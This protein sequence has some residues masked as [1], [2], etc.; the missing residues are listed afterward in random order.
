METTAR[1]YISY[2]VYSSAS[3]GRSTSGLSRCEDGTRPAVHKHEEGV[4]SLHSSG[5]RA[6]LANTPIDLA[7][8]LA[9]GLLRERG[10]VVARAE[11]VDEDKWRKQ[12][13]SPEDRA[14]EDANEDDQLSICDHTHRLVVVAY[15]R[16]ETYTEQSASKT[17][18][19]PTTEASSPVGEA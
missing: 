1:A 16:N 13:V 11:E 18:S 19:S 4:P 6:S 7:P 9:D 15:V 10:L 8:D 17:Y 2:A 14:E 12:A 5:R 3:S